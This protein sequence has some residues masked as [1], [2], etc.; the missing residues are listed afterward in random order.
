MSKTRVRDFG[1]KD[2]SEIR[3]VDLFCGIGGFR[4]AVAQAAKELNIK[5]SCVFSCDIDEGCQ[6]A[7]AANFAETP[8]GD[9]RKV[10]SKDI[11]A[12]DILFAGF[13]CQPFSIIGHKQG[14]DDTRGTL[15]FEIARIISNKKPDAFILENVKL[16]MGHNKGRTINTIIEI[17]RGIGYY[18]PDPQVLNALNFGLPQ[19][20]ER[21]FIIGFK[22][23]CDFQWP[24]GADFMTPLDDILESDVDP[25]YYASKEIRKKRLRMHPPTTETTIWHENKAGHI[26]AYRFSCALRAGASYNYLLVNGERRLTP[27]ELLRLQ[28]FPDSF[29]IVCSDTQ[30]RKQAGN[31]VPVPVV[32][33][34]IIQVLQALKIAPLV[35]ENHLE[36]K[37]INEQCDFALEKVC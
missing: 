35:T 14:F 28:G 12:H 1:N 22:K 23:R 20:R 8:Y 2:M 30:I 36:I 17:L 18:V 29:K 19:K 34:V 37:G 4:V 27:R 10:E 33:S 25:R 11:P 6:K 9:I 5:A 3:Y 32:K 16:L 26:S 21:V 7:Y 31:S 24:Q 15:F 13:P